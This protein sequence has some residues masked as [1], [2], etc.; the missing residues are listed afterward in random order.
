M[1]AGVMVAEKIRQ[2]VAASP[3]ATRA[4]DTAVTASFG[5][6]LDRPQRAGSVAQGGNADSRRR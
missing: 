5:S 1:P 4:G 6:G 2:L 3:F